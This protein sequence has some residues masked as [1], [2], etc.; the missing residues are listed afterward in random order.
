MS[1]YFGLLLDNFGYHTL[2]AGFDFVNFY[3][4]PE[5]SQVNTGM[6]FS[7]LFKNTCL[8]FKSQMTYA[9]KQY[10]FFHSGCFNFSEKAPSS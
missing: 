3:C 4:I 8:I 7:G 5:V 9:L 1:A 6:T 10:L 2:I